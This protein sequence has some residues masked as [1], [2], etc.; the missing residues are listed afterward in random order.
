[1]SSN[2]PAFQFY[3]AD[4]LADEHVALMSLAARGAYITLLCYCWREGSIPADTAKLARLC[5][6]DSSTM[7]ELMAELSPCFSS[8]IGEPSRLINLRLHE[9]R[10]K[11]ECY[12][13]ERALAGQKGAEKRWKAARKSVQKQVDAAQDSLAKVLPMAKNGSS[14]SSSSTNKNTDG[15]PSESESVKEVFAYW[16][17]RLDHPGAKLTAERKRKIVNRLEDG[18]TLEQIKTAIDGCA[19]SPFHRGD[20][21]RHQRY[22]DIELICRNGTKLESFIQMTVPISTST[23]PRSTP[24]AT[25]APDWYKEMYES[26]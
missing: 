15:K 2:S 14:S 7:A 1:M 18:Y 24:E 23:A 11:Q 12:R 25:S 10:K 16:Q 21:D 22:D 13:K 5:N 20:N 17:S 19:S 4:F 3:P 9:E 26:V 6:V 8:A